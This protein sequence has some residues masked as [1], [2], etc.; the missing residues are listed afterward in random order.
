MD[1]KIFI[2]NLIVMLP[3]VSVSP[4]VVVVFDG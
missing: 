2:F 4:W 1:A 3:P